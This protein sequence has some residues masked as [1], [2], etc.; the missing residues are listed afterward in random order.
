[1]SRFVKFGKNVYVNISNVKQ[2]RIIEKGVIIPRWK[3]Y[4]DEPNAFFD[5]EEVSRGLSFRSHQEAEA[6]LLE[7]IGKLEDIKSDTD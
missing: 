7:R 3:I 1:M 5:L 2:F 6:Y 4:H